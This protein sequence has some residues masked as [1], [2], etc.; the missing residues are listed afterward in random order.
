MPSWILSIKQE[1]ADLLKEFKDC[2]AWEYYE[3]SGL[4]RS[5]VEHR[6]PIKPGYQLFKQALRRFNPNVLDDI[7]KEIERLLEAKFIRLYQYEEWISNVV[8]MY[9]KNG[10]L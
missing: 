4:D 2:F 3:M 5:I 6:L 9:K 10:K 8:P 1:L 7:K